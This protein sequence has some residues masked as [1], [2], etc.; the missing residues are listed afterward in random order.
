MST[1]DLEVEV[2][3]EGEKDEKRHRAVSEWERGYRIGFNKGRA[4]VWHQLGVRPSEIAAGKVKVIVGKE[5]RELRLG[6][7]S[8]ETQTETKEVKKK[9]GDYMPLIVGIVIAA[10]LGLV[11]YHFVFGKRNQPSD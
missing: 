4:N 8:A 5:G 1:E 11:V 2:K 3:G 6:D 7:E 9:E 10:V